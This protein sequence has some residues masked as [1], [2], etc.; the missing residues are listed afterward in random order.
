M[1]TLFVAGLLRQL[2][3][4]PVASVTVATEVHLNGKTKEEFENE[5][6]WLSVGW[7]VMQIVRPFSPTHKKVIC[8]SPFARAAALAAIASMRWLSPTTDEHN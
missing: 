4:F 7:D 6:T 8:P 3:T 5:Y 1:H 2:P